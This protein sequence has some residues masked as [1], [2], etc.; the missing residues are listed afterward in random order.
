MEK[1]KRIQLN[2]IMLII[3]CLFPTLARAD[4]ISSKVNDYYYDELSILDESTKENIKKTNK[5]LESKTG[6]QIVVLSLNNPDGLE[7]MDYG[8]DLFNQLKLGDKVKDNGVLI[9]FLEDKNTDQR[10][11]AIIPGYGLEGILNDAKVGRIIDNFMLDYFKNGQYSK[12]IDEGFNAVVSQVLSEYDI[13]LDGNYEAYQENLEASDG[14]SM[15]EIL[16]ILV[17]FILISNMFTRIS[18]GPS[19]YYRGRRRRR[20]FPGWYGR[21]FWNDNDDD[22]FSG[23]SSGGGFSGGGFSGGGGSTGGGGASRKF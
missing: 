15:F 20:N 5:E 9:L 3:F 19:S 13:T 21:N 17:V 7:G 12:G 16:F 4:D 11:I 2:I 14:I 10:E 6:A 18:R 23:W 1:A 22:P 8:S